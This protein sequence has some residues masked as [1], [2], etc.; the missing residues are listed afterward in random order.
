MNAGDN[1]Q[2]K[3]AWDTLSGPRYVEIGSD[4]L[5]VESDGYFDVTAKKQPGK[6]GIYFFDARPT[7]RRKALRRRR[8]GNTGHDYRSDHGSIHIERF[9]SIRNKCNAVDSAVIAAVAAVAEAFTKNFE[10]RAAQRAARKRCFSTSIAFRNHFSILA[11]LQLTM[12]FPNMTH[13]H[14]SLDLGR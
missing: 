4:H 12:I 5:T 6:D 13:Y 14:A 10:I 11:D 8:D 9:I 2:I 7:A 1:L 3:A